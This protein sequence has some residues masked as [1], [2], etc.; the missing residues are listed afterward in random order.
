MTY[1]IRGSDFRAWHETL[2]VSKF[3][4]KLEKYKHWPETL[5]AC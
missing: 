3:A 2:K 5:I 1:L 4:S